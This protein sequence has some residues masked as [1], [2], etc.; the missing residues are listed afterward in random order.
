MPVQVLDIRG[1]NLTNVEL[2]KSLPLKTLYL[3]YEPRKHASLLSSIESLE[4]VNSYT[5]EA[6]M[7]LSSPKK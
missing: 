4:R 2:L 6:F 7:K 5:L 3:D 1:L